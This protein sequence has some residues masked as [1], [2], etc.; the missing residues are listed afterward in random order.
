MVV[1]FHDNNSGFTFVVAA[2]HLTTKAG[3]ANEALRTDQAFDALDLMA[4]MMVTAGTWRCL[5][6]GDLNT[7]P[8]DTEDQKSHTIPHVLLWDDCR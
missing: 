5:L 7:D 4:G 6:C 1:P 2:T 3:A 8:F